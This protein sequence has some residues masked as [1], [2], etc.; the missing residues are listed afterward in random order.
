MTSNDLRAE[1]DA[2]WRERLSEV[3]D[4]RDA[5]CEQ[6]DA[7]REWLLSVVEAGRAMHE[8]R[9]ESARVAITD[10]ETRLEMSDAFL[11]DMLA[12]L[13]R[14]REFLTATATPYPAHTLALLREIDEVTR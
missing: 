3:I 4:E 10:L 11:A 7:E 13:K 2:M 1:I 9:G 12:L 5:E 8:R 6:R 14:A